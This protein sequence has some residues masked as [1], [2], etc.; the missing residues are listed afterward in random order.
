MGVSELFGIAEEALK[1]QLAVI[2][3][4]KDKARECEGK[5]DIITKAESEQMQIELVQ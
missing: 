4:I 1:H 5:Q 3:S 2:K